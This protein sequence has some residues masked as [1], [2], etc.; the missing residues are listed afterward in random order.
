MTMA[1]LIKEKH[2]VG[3][4]YI[5]R[6]LVQSHLGGTWWLAGRQDAGEAAECPTS[7]LAGNRKWSET[8]DA[9]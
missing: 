9:A 1:T 3:V 5:F 6:D 2:L 4:A 7:W 8:L